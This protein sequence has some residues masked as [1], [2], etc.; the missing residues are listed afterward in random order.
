MVCDEC[1]AN[2]KRESSPKRKQPNPS[3]NLVQRTI[4]VHNSTLVLSKPAPVTATPPKCT[5]AKQ[6]HQF[7]SAID[8]L[9]QKIDTQTNTI[10]GLQASVNSMK[11]AVEQNT[12]TVTE[13]IKESRGTYA[14]IAKKGFASLGTPRSTKFVQ[15]PKPS[16]PTQTWISSK[17]VV[18]GK[19]SN[20]IGK[21]LSPP[22]LKHMARPKPE[23]AVWI[24]RIH[25]DT[26]EEDIS[27]YIKGSI[28][29][30]PTEFQVRK[31]VK[32]GRDITTYSFVSFYVACTQANFNTLMNPNH[33]P[34]NSQIREFELE[35]SSST[36]V[37]L[38]R[39]NLIA[40]NHCQF[41]T[42]TSEASRTKLTS[43]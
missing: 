5:T 34:S 28:G 41:I 22:Q 27:N 26:T 12:A 3:G 30:A 31:L 1:L 39:A 4:D 6:N 35:Q 23:K 33:W 36:G 32:K 21:A 14:D 8:A 7:Q 29:I 37:K 10:A 20:M 40:C 15:T 17:P 2:P 11:G 16:K 24:S 13:S 9:A 25:R 42:I 19:S 18:T 43:A 38:D